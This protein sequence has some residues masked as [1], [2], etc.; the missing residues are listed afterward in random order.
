M[1]RHIVLW[2]FAPSAAGKSREKNLEEAAS[3]LRALPSQI[4]S[5]K[6][7]QVHFGLPLG[8][9]S[10]DLVLVSSFESRH[11]LETYQAH[12]AHQE[13]ATFLRAV[14]SERAVVDFEL[15]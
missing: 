10:F 9:R 6:E 11:A 3:R 7:Y 13:V 4:P 15:P 2:K 8:E 1:I 14:Q 5:L 12:P